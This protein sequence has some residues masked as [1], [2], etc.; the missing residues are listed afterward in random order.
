MVYNEKTSTLKGPTML[1][2]LSIILSFIL[3]ST[4]V[5]IWKCIQVVNNELE[6]IESNANALKYT[7]QF[8]RGVQEDET[9]TLN[10]KLR[11]AFN[12]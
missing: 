8:L 3:S 9:M 12:I 6:I 4:L 7:I 10:K 2:A 5:L 11:A 1:I